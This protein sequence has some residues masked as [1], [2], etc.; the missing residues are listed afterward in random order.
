MIKIIILAAGKGVRMR[1]ELPKVLNK[2]KGEPMIRYLMKSV[3]WSAVDEKPIIVVS[4]KG[5][6]LVK[7]V[8][9]NFDCRYAV[10]KEQLGTGHAVLAARRLVRGAKRIIVL[11]GDHPFLKKETIIKMASPKKAV[12]TLATIKVKDFKEWRNNFFHWGRIIRKS[13]RVAGIIEFKDASDSEKKIKEV[14]PALYSFDAKW[15]WK[16][17]K[18]LKN[19][20]AQGEYYLTDLIRLAF[21]EGLKIDSFEI[22]PREAIG[23]NSKEELEA[24]ERLLK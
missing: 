7:K 22:D 2:V 3:K 18:K 10:Q 11:Y 24:A 6:D 19:N 21:E 15:L 5:K 14:N 1:S 17:L 8:L 12:I 23:I 16:N 13:G 9:K 20:N 4:S